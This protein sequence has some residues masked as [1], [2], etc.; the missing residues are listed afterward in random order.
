MLRS[1]ILI[2]LLTVATTTNSSAQIIALGAS[3]TAGY[4]VG[5]SAAYPAVLEELLRAKGRPMSVSNAGVSG[6]TTG[7]MLAR[8]SSVAPNGTKIVILQ[9]GGND[10]RKGISEAEAAAN[11]SEIQKRLHARGIRIIEVDGYVRSALQSG[12]RL[13]DGIHLTVEG[14]RKVAQQ[15]AASIR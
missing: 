11:R 12:L 14:H 15:L 13:A 2:C 7:G 5:P 4:G 9:I 6:D 8:L 3:N 1:L 10:R